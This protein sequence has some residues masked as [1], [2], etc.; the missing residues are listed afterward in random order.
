MFAL[1]NSCL[2]CWD[3]IIISYWATDVCGTIIW[4]LRGGMGNKTSHAMSI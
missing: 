2:T 4:R 3:N 1:D